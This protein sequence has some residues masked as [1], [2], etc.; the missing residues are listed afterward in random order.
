MLLV[1]SVPYGITFIS[2][3]KKNYDCHRSVDYKQIRVF[4]FLCCAS[5]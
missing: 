1:T 3:S 4:I 2:G 5:L